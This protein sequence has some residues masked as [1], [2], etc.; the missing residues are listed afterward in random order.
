MDQRRHI[1]GAE[2]SGTVAG[3]TI[4]KIDLLPGHDC[5]GL[6]GIGILDFRGRLGRIVEGCGLRVH[7]NKGG[8][9]NQKQDKGMLPP[10]GEE[11]CFQGAW[12][13]GGHSILYSY[14]ILQL[15]STPP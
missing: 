3:G 12:E 14:M 13:H 8:I 4:P 7:K 5:S 1:T 11:A 9:G 6:T 10:E 15:R 2:A